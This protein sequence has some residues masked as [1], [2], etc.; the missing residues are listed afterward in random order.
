MDIEE[1]G[2]R[3]VGRV[4]RVHLAAG[5]APQEE[6]VDGA[7][8]EFAGLGTPPR[9]LHPIEDPGEFRRRE[10]R[11]EEKPGPRG[12]GGFGSRLAKVGAGIGGPPILPD[13]RAMHRLAGLAVPDDDGLALVGDAERRDIG[14]P[15]PGLA[16]RGATGGDDG[17]PD[18]LGIMLDPAGLRKILRQFLLRDA[19]HLHRPVE[20]E[21]PRRGGSLV[22]GEDV[23]GAHAAVP[24]A[25]H[26]GERFDVARGRIGMRSLPGGCPM[27][28]FMHRRRKGGNR[29]PP[30]DRP[31]RPRDGDD[32]VCY[33]STAIRSRGGGCDGR[34]ARE[35]PKAQS[36]SPV[37]DPRG[38]RGHRGDRRPARQMD[39]A[40]GR[41]HRR[42]GSRAGICDRV[43]EHDDSSGKRH[44]PEAGRG[45][46]SAVWRTA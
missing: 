45:S 23:G 42:A 41:D 36:P 37:A 2:A 40:R 12:D 22:Y 17:A 1:K 15:D 43:H 18:F 35:G 20:D 44:P 6:G 39:A 8:A 33:P 19:D 13:D 26:P 24:R 32:R 11:I 25:G 7:G 46:R 31:P 9:A 3:G 30:G 16:N 29:R 14:R 10:I 27:F 38:R 34:A 21:G 5:Q 28:R 4:G